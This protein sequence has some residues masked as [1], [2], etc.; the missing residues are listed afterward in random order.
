M[1][2]QS[3]G[4]E[5]RYTLATQQLIHELKQVPASI[6][7]PKEYRFPTLP[8]TVQTH[9]AANTWDR[10]TATLQVTQG[11][12][13]SGDTTRRSQQ[14]SSDHRTPSADRGHS[15]DRDRRS[16]SLDSRRPRRQYDTNSS[17]S[18]R[19]NQSVSRSSTQP[20]NMDIQC[21]ACATN[22]HT[23]LDCR[24]FP[25]VAA[26]VE[27][28]TMNPSEAKDSLQQYRKA[29]HPDAR[30]AAREKYVNVL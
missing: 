25:K 24:L 19:S 23:H 29:Q 5:P 26:I 9:P 18:G 7:L 17:R 2:L 3:M 22:G 20:R 13:R 4:K 10:T 8:L 12:S 6:P 30:K 16:S 21:K 28:M 1:F 15:R 14:H 11:Y 27:Y